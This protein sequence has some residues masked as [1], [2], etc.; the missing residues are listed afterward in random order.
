MRKLALLAAAAVLPL[1]VAAGPASAQPAIWKWG[2]VHSADGMASSWGK[3]Y[4]HQFGYLVRGSLEDT[5]G[6]GCAW[7]VLNAQDSR[8][9]RWKSYGFY[10]CRPGVGTFKKDYR[11]VLRIRVQVCRGNA[12]RPTGECSGW[13][14]ILKMG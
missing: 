2:P 10:N 12:T 8:D 11:N 7:A 1:T 9:G 6:K 5:R 3:A 13:K 14:W 4:L